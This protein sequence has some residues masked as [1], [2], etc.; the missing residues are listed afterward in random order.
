MRML[1]LPPGKFQYFKT[2]ELIKLLI[3]FNNE[4]WKNL[5]SSKLWIAY[6]IL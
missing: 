5:I 6:I 4:L 3:D 2:D 1:V